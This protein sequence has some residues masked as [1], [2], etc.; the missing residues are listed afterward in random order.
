[1]TEHLN[2]K[3]ARNYARQ[4]LHTSTYMRYQIVKLIESGS[5]NGGYRQRGE[6]GEL[7]INEYKVS[8]MQDD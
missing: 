8:I 5:G 6:N 4:I 1:M 2:I 7:L 3:S